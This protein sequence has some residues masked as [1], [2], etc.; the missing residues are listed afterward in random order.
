ML[1]FDV[2]QISLIDLFQIF[3]GNFLLVTAAAGA[4]VF[5]QALGVLIQINVLIRL[6]HLA[7]NDVKK[8][9]IQPV[10]VIAQGNLGKNQRLKNVVIGHDKILK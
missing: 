5:Q 2:I 3:G 6:G 1:G 8:F 9:A 7:V 4:D 10:F